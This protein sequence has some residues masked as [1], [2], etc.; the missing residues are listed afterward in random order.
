MNRPGDMS[1]IAS[2]VLSVFLFRVVRRGTKLYLERSCA[3]LCGP[4]GGFA[5]S[6]VKIS[7][8]TVIAHL[9]LVCGK[10]GDFWDGMEWPLG[11]L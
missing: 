6:L 8:S 5:N 3:L 7:F 10:T 11:Q 2:A 4:L 1:R 9:L